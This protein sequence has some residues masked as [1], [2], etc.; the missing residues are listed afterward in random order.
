MEGLNRIDGMVVFPVHPRTR[1]RIEEEGLALGGHIAPIEPLSYL[2]LASLASQARVIVTDSGGL[3]KEAYW[4]GVPCVTVRPSTEW[5]D[6]VAEGANVLVDADPEAI[7]AAVAVGGDAR[8]AGPCCTATATPPSGSRRCSSLRSRADEARRRHRRSR[9]RR[10]PA[11]THVRR[12]GQARAARRRRP[13]RVAKL[14][15][16]ESYIEDVPTEV[17]KPLVDDGLVAATTDYDEIR[18]VDAI[19]VALPTPLSRQREPDLRILV[20][21]AEQI[22]DAAARGTSRRARVDDLPGDD[23]R[24]GAADPRAGQRAR[25]RARTSTSR[26]RPSASIPAARTGRRRTCRRWSGASTRGRPRRRPRSIGSAIDN[27]YR[28]SS[29]EAAELTKLL[30][31]IFRSVNIALVNELAQLCDRMGIDVWEVVEAAATKPF[32]FMSFQPGPGLGGHCI[33]VDPFYLTW[34]A[35]EFGFYTEFIEL[36]GKVNESMPYF[37]R[38]VVSQALNHARQRSL[39]G[40]K[41]LV[42]G[43]AYKPGISDTRESPAIKLIALLENAGA[44]VAYHD[45]HV[46]SFTENGI[47]HEL[48][49]RS[50][51]AR[52]TASSWSRTT[53]RS[54]TTGSSTSRV[55]VVDLRNATGANGKRVGQGLEALTVRIGQAGLGE[56]GKNLARNFA[57]L[58]ELTWLDR[59]GRRQG[60]RVPARYPQARWADSFDEMLADTALDAV[61]IATP[62]PTHYELAKRALEAGKHVFVEKPPAMKG[63]EID[64]LVAIA[65]ERDLVLMPGHLLL[66]HPGVLKLKELV[67]TG[68]LGDVLCVYGNRQNLGRIRPYENALWS[69]GVHDLSVILHLLDEDPV[70]AIAL[71]R[72]FLQPGVEDVVFCYLRF[73]SGRI[74]HMHL[75]WLDPHKMRK[76]TVV[77]TEKM[78]V[79]D[80]MELDRK[81]TVYEKAPWKPVNT[82]GEWQT[83]T[84][85]I[86]IPKIATD[87]PLRLECRHFLSLVEGDGDRAQV[88][89]DGAR[90]VR[91][92]DMLTSLARMAAEVHP[93]A[94]VYPGTV[95]GEGVKVLENAVVGKQPSLSPR[96]TAKRE[97]AASDGDR[98]RH[99]RLHRRDRLRRLDGS[100]RA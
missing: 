64:E 48:R 7:A 89:R 70:E 66:Y 46:P 54:T 45:P 23:P 10:R 84:G 28:V 79:F 97:P 1:A 37:C 38:S 12:R 69:L 90:V 55:L 72:D 93:S 99:D 94:I 8:R 60:R 73:P 58:A 59:P 42:L 33:P 30:E 100:A 20:S 15:A 76:M 35:R 91:A 92:L 29:P 62:V 25:G 11:R 21:A 13:A 31:N 14:N 98:R 16:G 50:S 3:Q 36:A 4:Y 74:A 19:L 24:A 53:R 22:V 39:K 57:D 18:D 83:R 17:L 44:D 77:G 32:G 2:E 27:I 61:V 78:A 86:H 80:D 34:K 9:L 88:A 6:T 65:E 43:V 95:L 81:V 5:V 47:S 49:R 51:R 40:S 82:Y 87:E 71:G 26:S 56:W 52:T 96:S 85:D 67:D 41:I 63:A 75:S 68:E